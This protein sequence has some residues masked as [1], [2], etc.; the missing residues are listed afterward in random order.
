MKKIL[1]IDD[2]ERMLVELI[3]KKNL[4][5]WRA[6]HVINLQVESKDWKC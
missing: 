2:E 4:I 1:L 5:P 3:R 6:M